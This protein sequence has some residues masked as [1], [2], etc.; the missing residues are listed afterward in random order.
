MINTPLPKEILYSWL[1]I[2]LKGIA[3]NFETMQNYTKHHNIF[4]VI[5]ADAYGHG[6]IEVARHLLTS[7]KTPPLKF[8]VARLE[9]ALELRSAGIT[10]PVFVLAAPTKEQAAVAISNNIEMVVYDEETIKTISEIANAQG[11]KAFVHLKT[12]IGMGR[13]GCRP[14]NVPTLG[15]LIVD[16]PS[17]V[18]EGMMSHMPFADS[19]PPERTRKMIEI[20]KK[21]RKCLAEQGTNPT[22]THLANSASILDFP[23]AHFNAVRLGICLYGQEPSSDVL[24]KPKLVPGMSLYTRVAFLK[25]VPANQGISYMHLYTTTEPTM[26]ATLPV[27]YADGLPRSATNKCKVLIN[28]CLAPE[29]GRIC[30]DQM[31][32]NVNGIPDVHVGSIATVFGLSPDRKTIRPVEEF[33]DWAGTIGYEITTRIGKRLIK[34]YNK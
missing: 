20:F 16:S 5:K 25:Q 28:D 14:E 1:E 24:T 17:L 33:A 23:E 32:I 2:N 12:D 29:I 18:F 21:A 3:A 4:V 7:V 26:V 31:M 8:A 19:P 11:K 34:F 9:E 30:M 10:H 6:A 15:K 13:V 22:Y 27:G